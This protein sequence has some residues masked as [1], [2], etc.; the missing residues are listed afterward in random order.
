[1]AVSLT[2]SGAG[3]LDRGSVGAT[4]PRRALMRAG[5][6]FVAFLFCCASPLVAQGKKQPRD[7]E[8]FD[9]SGLPATPKTDVERQIFLFLKVHKKGDLTDATRIHMMLAQYYK[10]RGDA[11]RADDCT[12]LAADAWNATNGGPETAAASGTPPFESKGTFRKTFVYSDDLKVEHTWAFYVDGTFSHSVS[13]G[14][15][16]AGPN[17]TGWYTRQSGRIRLWQERPKTDKTVDFELLGADGE[18]G[19]VMAGMRM[20]PEG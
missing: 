19:A 9:V 8:R 12:H 14:A 11:A 1:V 7:L 13:G 15:D 10:E 4:I 20:K 2:D 6:L 3:V 16:A 5:I 17:E 18:G